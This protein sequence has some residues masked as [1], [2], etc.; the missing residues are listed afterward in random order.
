MGLKK[1]L[2]LLKERDGDSERSLLVSISAPESLHSFYWVFSMLL[3]YLSQLT[4]DLC[5]FSVQ[6]QVSILQ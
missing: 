2:C 6:F 5:C 4:V 3:L 1:K